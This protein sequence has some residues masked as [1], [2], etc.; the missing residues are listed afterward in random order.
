M[1]LLL[2]ALALFPAADAD[3]AWERVVDLR[4]AWRF[5]LGDD[6]DRAR[7]G[8]DDEA[9]ESISVPAAWEDEG[10]WGYDGTAWYRRTFGLS[11]RDLD[12]PLYLHLG[13]VDD[14]DQVWVNGHFVGST[15]RF[16]ES[17]YESA[18]FADRVYPVP[19]EYL[20]AGANVVAVRVYDDG[21]DGGLLEG[22]IGV[23]ALTNGPDLAVDLAG[24]WDFRPGDDTRSLP[25][26]GWTTLTVPARWEPQGFPRL[27]GYAWYRRSFTLPD[28]LRSESLVLVLGRIDDLHEATLNG[29]RLGGS[30]GMDARA[31][32][33]TEWK[34]LRAYRLDDVP[35][36]E[37]NE[38]VVRVYDAGY[39]GGIY[40]G[41]VGVMTEAAFDRWQSG[42]GL[43]DRLRSF[44][45][46]DG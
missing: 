9:W 26:S 43:I 30:G 32:R 1:L 12:R 24:A 45:R 6:L 33:G 20:R 29:R 40:D 25:R 13:R 3:P 44:F 23:Y 17:G 21:L 2:L 11:K 19:A 46:L 14:A 16:P 37:K 31:V 7:A 18:Y 22:R 8:Y 39:E 15:G 35:L 27:D 34:A 42:G 4:G 28:R 36:R 10:F 38:I 5:H 41:P